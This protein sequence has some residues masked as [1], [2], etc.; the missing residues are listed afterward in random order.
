MSEV[1]EQVGILDMS[2]FGKLF[3]KEFGQSPT[4]YKNAAQRREVAN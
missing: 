3:K 1:T 2:H 4:D